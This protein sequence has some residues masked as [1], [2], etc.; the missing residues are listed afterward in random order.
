MNNLT[1][2]LQYILAILGFS[3]I[4]L[5]HE[6]GHFLMAKLNGIH[7]EEF[8]IGLGPKLLKFK[9]K[10]GT[11]WGLSAIPVG[12]YNKI[13]GM[14]RDAE[15]PQEMEDKSY[16]KKPLYR[17]FLVI[18]GGVS[19][20]AVFAVLLIAVFLSMG[21]F[22]PTTTIGYIEPDSPA[23]R[24]GFKTGDKVV[25]LN[26]QEVDSWDEFAQATR[27]H[28]EDTARYKVIRDGREATI[29]VEL[30]ERE[31]GRYLGIG[32]E[33]VKEYL[34]F[35]QVIKESF[36]MTGDIIRTYFMLFGMLFSGQLSFTE[37]RPVSPVGVVSIF[38]QSAAMGFQNFILFVALVSLLLV[39][40]NLLPILP[41]DGGHLLVLAIEGFRKKPLSKRALEIFNTIGIILL[42]SL[43]IIGFVY[44][45]ISPFNLQNM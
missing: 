42:V 16:A 44:D 30:E 6:F 21:V 1:I 9:S 12:G 11:T 27:E 20:N 38:Q 43:L 34:S 40:G 4:V 13:L 32:P 35:G 5:V 39:F 45:I 24:Y 36:V 10:G 15:V 2:I 33:V 37:A 14:D 3:F 7:V 25:A 41:L 31:G 19:L 23:D 22:A 26:S 17:K 28:P 18:I 8:F 29:Q